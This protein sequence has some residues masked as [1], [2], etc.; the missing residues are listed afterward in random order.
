MHVCVHA[1]TEEQVQYTYKSVF[2]CDNNMRVQP[3]VEKLLFSLFDWKPL[4]LNRVTAQQEINC[5]V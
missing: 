4:W 1:Y 3:A 5:L 2:T